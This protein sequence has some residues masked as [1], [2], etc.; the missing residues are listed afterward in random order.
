MEGGTG[1][2]VPGGKDE[3]RDSGLP[4]EIAEAIPRGCRN[5]AHFLDRVKEEI[6]DKDREIAVV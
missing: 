6:T 1:D 2:D 5:T 3:E 4:G